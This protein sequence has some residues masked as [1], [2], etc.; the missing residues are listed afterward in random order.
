MYLYVG[1]IPA[2]FSYL[3]DLKYSGIA[4]VHGSWVSKAVVPSEEPF[5]G[6]LPD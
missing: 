1:V 4:L 5:T 3:S 6:L 2:R